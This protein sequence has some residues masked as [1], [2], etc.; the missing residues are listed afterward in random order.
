M[1][2]PDGQPLARKYYA[3][4]TGKDL[5]VDE[6]VRGFEISKEKF[7]IVTDEELDR[8]AASVNV[9]AV[10]S[11][12]FG[13]LTGSGLTNNLDTVLALMADVV[14]NPLVSRISTARAKNPKRVSKT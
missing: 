3:E 13:Q 10:I 2:G 12:G 8:L 11:A 4:K 1:L 6:V 7:V 14:M 9:G 5:D